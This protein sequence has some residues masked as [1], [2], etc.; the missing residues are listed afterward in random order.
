MRH[1]K[2]NNKSEIVAAMRKRGYQV[3]IIERPLDLL[4]TDGRRTFLVE[5]KANH[6]SELTPAQV[7][8]W[9]EWRGEKHRVTNVQEALSL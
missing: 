4:V 5:V 1:R 8:F 6:K 3:Y 9:D 2:D 7:Q